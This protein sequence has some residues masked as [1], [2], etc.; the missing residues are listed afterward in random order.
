M[1][2]TKR[3]LVITGLLFLALS[4]P[5]RASVIINVTET[6]G[7][8][9]LA[10]SG[11]LDLTGLTNFGFSSAYP[12][13][14][15]NQGYVIIGGGGGS[16]FTQIYR[17]LSGP[18]TFGTGGQTLRTSA[19]GDL[20]SISNFGQWLSVANGFVSGSAISGSTSFVGA[21]IASLGMNPG[22]YTWSWSND[23]VSLVVPGP[24]VIPLPMALPLLG[25]GL[26]LMGLVSWRRKRAAAA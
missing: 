14:I 8:V 7:G 5:T 3:L 6:G 26:G 1:S 21:T 13:V 25:T 12:Q 10:A 15:P 19:P 16:V 4:Q 22:T 20:I 9:D 17:G 18:T 24:N 23:F 11:T 2:A